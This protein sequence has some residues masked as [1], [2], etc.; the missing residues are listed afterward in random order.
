MIK[1]NSDLIKG[2]FQQVID[3]TDTF[4]KEESKKQ[5][6]N[7]LNYLSDFDN[8]IIEK[9]IKYSTEIC[10]II[11]EKT[12]GGLVTL[13]AGIFYSFL[14]KEEFNEE[15]IKNK[16]GESVSK[17]LSGLY[18]IPNFTTK[19]VDS[20]SENLIKFLLTI[21]NDVRAILIMLATE[22][23]NIRNIDKF[24]DEERQSVINRI[25]MLYTPLAH[26]IG[27]YNIKTEFEESVMKHTEEDMYRLIAK[28]LQETKASR[29]TYISNFIK[30][31]QKLIS[32]AGFTA[33][34]KG[35]P[36]SIHS[37]WNKMKSQGVP[38]EE[39]YDLFAIRIILK[40]DLK[41]EKAV[42]WN[43]YS[44]ITD[45]YKPN[46]KRLRD[47]ISAPKLSGYESLHTT[48]LGSENKWV[49]VQIR[50]ERMDEVA[51]KGPAAHWRYKTGKEGG[52]NDWLA[53]IREE[54]ENPTD[55]ENDDKSKKALYSEEIL[56][57][58]P[59]GDV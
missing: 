26:R 22:L 52:N 6:Y 9:R 2:E 31:L 49:E 17:I 20:Q 34:I 37:I 24:N 3:F 36:K 57:F 43:V 42:C 18:K 14:E 1:I 27:L 50:T 11:I 12:G 23:Y 25:K 21:T 54:I 32:D 7:A 46:P 5:I 30:P 48:V 15:D 39:V 8:K 4:E 53:K 55:D 58:T 44:L 28:K 35:R 45:L 16:F 59:E 19:K 10:N 29:D 51:E 56:V 47:W 40:S 38:F 33:T 13:L 41:N